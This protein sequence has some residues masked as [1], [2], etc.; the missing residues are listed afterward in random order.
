MGIQSYYSGHCFPEFSWHLLPPMGCKPCFQ[1]PKK[2][3]TT[4]DLTQN[5]FESRLRLWGSKATTLGNAYLNSHA[6]SCHPR[7][8]NLVFNFPATLKKSP[9]VSRVAFRRRHGACFPASVGPK[10]ASPKAWCHL[11][12]Q[13]L[14]NQK[15]VF[16]RPPWFQKTNSGFV[17]N[18]RSDSQGTARLIVKVQGYPPYVLSKAS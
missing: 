17:C 6:T 2:K 15:C 16:P 11:L 7:G 9:M 12:P 14:E 13:K 8:V 3:N 1:I 18:R 10:K 5:N 4:P